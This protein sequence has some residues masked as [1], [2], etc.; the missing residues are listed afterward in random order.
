[1]IL[2][3]TMISRIRIYK[4]NSRM[5]TVPNTPTFWVT[6]I[7]NRNVSL[8]DLDLTIKAFTSVN[9]LDKKHYPYTL[10]QLQKS[11]TSGSLFAKKNMIVPRKNPPA[12]HHNDVTAD[13]EAVIPSRQRSL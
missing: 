10:E 8:A 11:A 4:H 9:L 1:M 7:C 3:N 5:K 13:R 2:K 6:N 12:I